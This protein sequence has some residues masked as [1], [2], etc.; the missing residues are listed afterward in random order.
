LAVVDTRK[1]GQGRQVLAKQGEVVL[2]VH[3]PN[4]AHFFDGVFVVHVANQGI[5]GISGNGQHAPGF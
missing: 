5:A 4:A 3:L 1:V 2:V